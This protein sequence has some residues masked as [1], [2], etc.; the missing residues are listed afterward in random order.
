MNNKG[1]SVITI[2]FWVIVFLIGFGMFFSRVINETSQ[3]AIES[4]SVTGFEA[5]VFANLT[6]FIIIALLIFILAYVYIG[7]A[8]G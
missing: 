8:S 4:G 2:F 7:G 6:V 5:F 3:Q 1:Q